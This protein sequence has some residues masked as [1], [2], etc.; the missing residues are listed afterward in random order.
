MLDDVE[1]DDHEAPAIGLVPAGVPWE[2]VLD[3]IKI[4]HHPLLITPGDGGDQYLGAYWANAQLALAEDLGSDQDE[5]IGEFRE[6]L[7]ERGEA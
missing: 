5:A 1:Y 4:A 2:E 6:F 3:H 7:R